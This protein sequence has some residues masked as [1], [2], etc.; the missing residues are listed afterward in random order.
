MVLR[1]FFKH[2]FQFHIAVLHIMSFIF[3]WSI[4]DQ[5]NM[6]LVTS[7]YYVWHPIALQTQL[8]IW[9][10]YAQRNL[11]LIRDSH[12]P[13]R[14][15]MCILPQVRCH[16]PLIWPPAHPLNLTYMWLVPSTIIREPALYKLLT[17]HVPN[18]MSIFHRLSQLSKESI[19]VRGSVEVFV[20]SFFLRWGVVNPTHNPKLEDHPLLSV[21]DCLF[22]AVNLHSW[23]SFLH[24]QPED[25]PCCG[26][27]SRRR[28]VTVGDPQ[29]H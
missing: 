19:Q 22:I 7:Y 16:R 18:L 20:T 9:F 25:A 4:N 10:S 14:R 1:E 2:M 28:N 12:S 24:L 29:T 17:F 26:Q 3:C 5:N 13:F 23:R 27:G 8:L 21:R 11:Y 15:K 6:T